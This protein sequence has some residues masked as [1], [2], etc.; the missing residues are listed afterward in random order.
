LLW[1]KEVFFSAGQEA[2]LAWHFFQT[3]EKDGNKRC[4]AGKY[5]FSQTSIN[6]MLK[7]SE[8]LAQVFLEIFEVIVTT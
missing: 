2:N 8:P 3:E 4:V 7:H 1:E 5:Y 6:R